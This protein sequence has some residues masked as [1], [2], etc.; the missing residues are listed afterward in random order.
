MVLEAVNLATLGGRKFLL[1]LISGAGT[2]LLVCLGKIDGAIYATVTIGTVGAY[3]AG[4]V[5]ETRAQP[6]EKEPQA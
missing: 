2:F 4:N 5:V 3:I 6:R 1:T